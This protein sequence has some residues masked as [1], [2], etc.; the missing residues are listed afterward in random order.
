VSLVAGAGAIG[1]ELARRYAAGGA[2]VV[3]GDL[4]VDIAKAAADDIKAAGG[5]R[6]AT[7]LDGSDEA[8]LAEA[9]ALCRDTYG[10][11][12]GAHLN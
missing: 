10:G 9:V 6:I 4:N 11:L 3:V 8:S 7:R 1:S 2:S 12:D 5:K